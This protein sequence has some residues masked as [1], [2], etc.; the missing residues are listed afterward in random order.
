MSI[1][2]PLKFNLFFRYNLISLDICQAKFIITPFFLSF[3]K[4]F[5]FIILISVPGAKWFTF[6][7]L[8]FSYIF[9]IIFYLILTNSSILKLFL[10]ML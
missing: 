3:K 4:N 5:S 7:E 2:L 6:N 8:F 1:I 9:E 10:E